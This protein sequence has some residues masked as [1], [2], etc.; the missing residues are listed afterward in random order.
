VKTYRRHNCT[1]NHRTTRT[2]AEC[3]FRRAAWIS[4]T[5]DYACLAWCDVLTV[6]L[7]ATAEEA[8]AAKHRIDSTACGSRCTKRHEVARLEKAAG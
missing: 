3:M 7:Y 8:T 2:L 5:G 4:G 6:Q 1:K